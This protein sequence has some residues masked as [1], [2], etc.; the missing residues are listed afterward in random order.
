MS[1]IS[2]GMPNYNR[3]SQYSPEKLYEISTR[4]DKY[5]ES[6]LS[7]RLGKTMKGNYIYQFKNHVT[8]EIYVG[9]SRRLNGRV[10]SHL[11]TANRVGKSSAKKTAQRLYTELKAHPEWFTFGFLKVEESPREIEKKAIHHYGK[12]KSEPLYN[13]NGGGGGPATTAPSK[14]STAV[15]KSLTQD[16]E[17]MLN[18]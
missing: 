15:V 17:N 7:L 13:L 5:G 1:S 18:L 2:G 11:S 12:K 8:G 14:K 4:I 10:S 16:F 9:E 3:T 6:R